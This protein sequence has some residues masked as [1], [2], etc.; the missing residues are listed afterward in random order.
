MRISQGSLLGTLLWSCCPAIAMAQTYIVDAANGLGANFTDLPAAVAAVPDGAV[1]EVRAGN[2]S[3]FAIVNK[4]LSVLFAPGAMIRSPVSGTGWNSTG[5]DIQGVGPTQTVL[6]R[7]LCISPN[8]SP[9]APIYRWS[10]SNSQGLVLFEDCG[11]QPSTALPPSLSATNCLQVSLDRCQFGY[12]PSCRHGASLVNSD[13]VFRSCGVAW[14][15]AIGCRLQFL[16]S[17]VDSWGCGYPSVAPAI[18][19]TGGDTRFLAGS[20]AIALFN[21][22]VAGSGVLRIDPSATVAPNFHSIQPNY[23]EMPAVDATGGSLG[24]SVTTTMRGPTGDVGALLVGL[25]GPPLL[26]PGFTDSLWLQP[27]TESVCTFAALA[28][29]TPLTVTYTVPNVQAIRGLRL[30]W[31]GVSFGATNGLQASNPAITMHW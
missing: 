12:S 1:L 10:L 3:G 25:P 9:I 18:Q 6:L 14:V 26:F 4:G 2:Y 27:G 5:V 22:S 23:L 29:G 31:H 20:A 30:C 16:D 21:S 7:G 19:M 17:G 8:I 13:V 15:G 24:A 28:A 11:R